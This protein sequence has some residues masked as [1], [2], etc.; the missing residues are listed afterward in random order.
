MSKFLLQFSKIYKAKISKYVATQKSVL[1]GSVCASVWTAH[2]E[3]VLCSVTCHLIHPVAYMRVEIILL[4][5]ES[6]EFSKRTDVGVYHAIRV[7]TVLN[8]NSK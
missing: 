2:S 3:L 8:E 1:L 7:H 6:H 5:D 4:R